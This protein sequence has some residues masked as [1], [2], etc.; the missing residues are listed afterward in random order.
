MTARSGSLAVQGPLVLSLKLCFGALHSGTW[1]TSCV[2]RLAAPSEGVEGPL[3]SAAPAC[4]GT[5]RPC[6]PTLMEVAVVS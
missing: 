3:L 2:S 4:T 6:G 5:S 1:A